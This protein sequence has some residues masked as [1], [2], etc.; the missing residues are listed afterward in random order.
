M[1]SGPSPSQIPQPGRLGIRSFQPTDNSDQHLPK[2]PNR[3][4]GDRSFQPRGKSDRSPT[5]RLGDLGGGWSAWA[6]GNNEQP[7][8]CRPRGIRQEASPV[9]GR[10]EQSPACR[11]GGF[12]S[13][14]RV[15]L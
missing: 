3:E 12:G 14:R 8:A 6:V 15:P 7:A 9:V 2:S 1:Q 10:N 4:V 11:P 13:S 5:S